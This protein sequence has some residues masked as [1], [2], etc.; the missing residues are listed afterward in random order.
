MA[1]PNIKVNTFSSK[2]LL[3]ILE[4]ENLPEESIE[5]KN[6]IVA[7]WLNTTKEHIEKIRNEKEDFTF[8]MAPKLARIREKTPI[9]YV[10]YIGYIIA[11]REKN[12]IDKDMW[13][14][15]LQRNCSGGN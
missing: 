10:A 15:L 2:Q 3:E 5:E 13:Y 12:E 14:T 6:K 7:K 1:L 11:E 9:M 4:D 8:Q